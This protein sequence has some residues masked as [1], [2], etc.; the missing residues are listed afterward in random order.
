MKRK[1]ATQLI[2]F[3]ILATLLVSC[4]EPAILPTPTVTL[5]PTLTPTLT[6]IPPT[7]TPLPTATSTLTPTPIPTQSLSLI[8][9]ALLPAAQG[10][11]VAEAAVYDPYKAGIHPIVFIAANDQKWWNNN[12][13]ESWRPS[14]VSQVE[15]VAVL[16]FINDQ[17]EAQRYRMSGGGLVTVRSYRVDTE[18]MLREART[19]NLIATTLFRGGPSPALPHKIPAGTQAFYGDI[20]AYEIVEL[21]LKDYVEK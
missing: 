15:L 19:G 5:L 2:L 7:E 8:S 16:R 3:V 9:D 11:E 17:I 13:P 18:V 10:M 4:G 20:V 1:S 6:P 21:W 12:L 14:N